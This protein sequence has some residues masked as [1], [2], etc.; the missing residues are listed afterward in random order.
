ME[1]VVVDSYRELS[2][3]AA[4]RVADLIRRKPNAVLGLATGSTPLGL[5]EELVRRHREE[6]LDFSQVTTF[7]L[8]EYLGLPPDHPASYHYFM[9]ENLFAHINVRPGAVHI[10]SGV[11]AD[12]EQ[13]CIRYEEAIRQA[14]GIDL[15]ILGIGRNG[16]IGFN[17]PGTPFD[18]RTHVVDLAEDTR[19]ANARFFNSIDEVPRRAVTMGIAT[20]MEAREILLLASGPE[21]AWAVARTLEGEVT[22]EVPASVL[23]RHPRVFVV[24]DRG[25]AAQVKKLA[26]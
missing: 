12:I 3:W 5:Y 22:P 7:N 24:A 13:E 23:Q 20:I 11:A 1:L 15:Q 18:S 17:E 9:R 19:R 4:N 6:G 14:G 10:P 25:A 26:G 16:H 21:K 8:D 2:L